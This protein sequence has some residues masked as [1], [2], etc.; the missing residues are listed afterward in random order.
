M[1]N[2]PER[3]IFVLKPKFHLACHVS[4]RLTCRTSRA[5]R[6]VLF[7]KLDTAKMHGLDT[8][9]VSSRVET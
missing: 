3:I 7:D 1:Q 8:L 9:N 2:G 6:A 4:T 5:C